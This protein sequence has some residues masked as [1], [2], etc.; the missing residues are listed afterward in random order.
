MTILFR[1]RKLEGFVILLQIRHIGISEDGRQ[2][3]LVVRN[4]KQVKK[5]VPI[6]SP[7]EIMIGTQTLQQGL[8]WYLEKYLELPIDNFR[9]QAEEIQ[10]A[11]SQWKFDCFKAL[12]A[13]GQVWDWYHDTQQVNTPKSQL[14]IIS[15]DAVVLSWP[16]EVLENLD[17]SLPIQQCLIERLLEKVGDVRTLPE[18]LPAGQLNILYIIARPYGDLD[19]GFQTLAR[20]LIDFANE[21]GW[22]VHIDVLRPPTFDQLRAAL[23]ENP[24]F[25]H[26]IHFDGHGGY[27]DSRGNQT[28]DSES[29]GRL[30]FEKEDSSHSAHEVPGIMLAE[31]LQEHKI[32]VMVLNACQSAMQATDPFASVAVSLLKAGIHGVVAMSYSLRVSGAKVFVPAFYQNLFQKGDLAEA[33]H[34]GRREMYRNQMRDTF[35]GQVPFCD[36]IVPVLY[37][38][39]VEDVLPKLEPGGKHKSILPNEAQDLGDYGFIGRDRAIK[40][41][42]RAIRLDQAG[43]LIHGM[44]GEGKTT[45]AKGFLQW[46]KA[47]H[48]LGNGVFWFSFEDIYSA[49]YS[50]NT[51]AEALLGTQAMALP[52]WQKLAALTK[53]LRKNRSFIVWDNFE[54]AS[55]I[56]GTEV[57]ALL[58]EEDRML[59]KKL[60]HD[61]HGGQSKVLI[62]SRSPESW[63]TF[64]ECCRLPLEGLKGEELWQYC[65]AVVTNLRLSL[66]RKSE[67]YKKLMDKLEGNP[68][69]VRVILLRLREKSAEALLSELEE[70]FRGI[71]GDEGMRRIQ[72]ALSVFERGL[73]RTFAP[74]LRLIGLHEHCLDA[75]LLAEMLEGTREINVKLKDCLIALESAGLCRLKRD[76][77]YQIHPALRGC[78]TRIH[79]AEE[80]ERQAFV[81]IMGSLANIYVT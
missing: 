24:G 39:G 1:H 59:L 8:R 70:D 69:A 67:T 32:P 15:D 71:E 53:I 16:W 7:W 21:D 26:I 18:K 81:D 35:F 54:S 17:R 3:F 37:Q 44:A 74:A 13:D 77:Q 79:P 73:D 80:Y 36:W 27:P 65:N 29:S 19:V 6:A 45:L 48:G 51:L 50:I 66:D 12:L 78:L 46:L 9:T 57:S 34:A 4:G 62:T 42:E 75:E 5:P 31:L 2:L 40:N 20:P 38:Q 23:E 30:V 68:L 25:Y 33:I 47:T 43:I 41:L 10:A 61:L 64:Q 76:K 56:P 63:L 52:A 55:G 14:Q 11:L 22:P 72:A 28:K 49:E 60:L 58:P